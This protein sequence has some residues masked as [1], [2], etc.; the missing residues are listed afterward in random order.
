MRARTLRCRP[1]LAIALAWVAPGLLALGACGAARLQPLQPL[2]QGAPAPGSA[3]GLG[4]S[5]AA[6]RGA[7]TYAV[8]F[9]GPLGD[10][11]LLASVELSTEFELVIRELDRRG[12]SRGQSGT[13]QR[14]RHRIRYRVR[15]GPPD[16]DIGDLAVD[17]A[18]QEAWIASRDGTARSYD[19][20]RGALALTWHLG[21]PAT[22]V[23][24]SA[25]G[26]LVAT[27]T[28]EG[29]LCV[30]RRADSALLQCVAAHE[31]PIAALDF[32]AGHLA[33]AAWDGT[34]IVWDVPSLAIVARH[35]FDG[36]VNDLAFTPDG[37]VLAL[38]RSASPP[39]RTPRSREPR[40]AASPSDA[41]ALVSLWHV[42]GRTLRHLRGHGDVVT[43]VAWVADGR[44]LV[45]ASWDRS[46]RLWDTQTGAPVARHTAFA[47]LVRD[48]AVDARGT[49]VAAGAWSDAGSLQ[50]STATA[51]IELLYATQSRSTVPAGD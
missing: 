32:A 9:A 42:R 40:S 35:R 36:S 16:F 11:D 24:I 50:E 33:S 5:T 14:V 12:P 15:L 46:V 44:G 30:R 38:A 29:V 3:A 17:H 27:A 48:V 13:G 51:L 39:V 26:R 6:A 20:T 37:T 21:S 45:S 18:R 41:L 10:H 25:D 4:G 43:A 49:W 8:A 34:V 19:L 22:A 2:S 1:G 28:D 47:G 31:A 23:A 7:L